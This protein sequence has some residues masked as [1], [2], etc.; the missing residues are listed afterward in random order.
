MTD[1]RMSLKCPRCEYRVS[2]NDSL[3]PFVHA[4]HRAMTLT[5]EHV[6]AKHAGLEPDLLVDLYRRQFLYPSQAR[7]LLPFDD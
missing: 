7:A 2:V 3:Y 6:E 5:R 4:E 1:S